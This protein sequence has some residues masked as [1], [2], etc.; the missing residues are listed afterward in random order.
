[1]TKSEYS[2]KCFAFSD[3][4]YVLFSFKFLSV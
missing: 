3:K 2:A 1:M 4:L